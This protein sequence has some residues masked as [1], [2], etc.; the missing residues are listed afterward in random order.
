MSARASRRS[1]DDV[2]GKIAPA[3]APVLFAYVGN[4]VREGLRVVGDAD[5]W[6]LHPRCPCA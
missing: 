2:S 6:I 5:P 3:L 1:A 4:A